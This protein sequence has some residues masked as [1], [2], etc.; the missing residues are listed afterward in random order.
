MIRLLWHEPSNVLCLADLS[1]G[2]LPLLTVCD[3]DIKMLQPY[4]SYP[5][6]FLLDY[7]GFVDLGEF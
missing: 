3:N 4:Y 2:G 5:L 1:G 7:Y 6:Q